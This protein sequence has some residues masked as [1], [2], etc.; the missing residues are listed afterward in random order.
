[1]GETQMILPEKGGERKFKASSEA[2]ICY[3]W[4][5]E[6]DTSV[7]QQRHLARHRQ[8]SWSL[9]TANAAVWE[10]VP[11]ATEGWSRRPNL[12]HVHG[13]I[14]KWTVMLISEWQ[15][16]FQFY[17]MPIKLPK[18]RTN[19]TQQVYRLTCSHDFFCVRH[20]LTGPWTECCG[21]LQP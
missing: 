1:M 7:L 15:D 9:N 5:S 13:F 2:F 4:N 17:Y 11:T 12:Q 20:L 21:T 18:H 19:F 14:K 10:G 8:H 6:L 3:L 16:Q